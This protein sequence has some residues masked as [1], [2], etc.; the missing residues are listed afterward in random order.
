MK[1]RQSLALPVQVLKEAEKTDFG[2]KDSVKENRQ[3][4]LKVNWPQAKRGRPGP[5][6]FHQNTF[7]NFL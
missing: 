6:T 3:G 4:C 2:G 5:F 7:Q 1:S